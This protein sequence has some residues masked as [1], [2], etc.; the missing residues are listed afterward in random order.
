MLGGLSFGDISLADTPLAVLEDF[1]L[2]DIPGLDQA[3]IGEFAGWEELAISEVPGLDQVPFGNFPNPI[4]SILG[5]FGGTHDVTYGP[6]EH[7]VTPTK[8]A[9]TGSDQEGFSVQCAQDNGCAYLELEGPGAM[10]GAQWIAGG[11]GKGQQ[12]VEGGKGLLAM[13][14]GGKEPTGRVPF[15]DVFKI[16]LTGTDE[17]SGKGDFALYMR[18][19]QKAM[20]VDLGC[21]PY[22]IGPIPIWS[23]KEKGFVRSEERRVGKECRSRWSPYH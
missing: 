19:C 2:G 16:V 10:H 8:F 11:S 4:A 23:T 17:A 9:I 13:V 20:F 15:G 18:Y 5:G 21:T 6:K 1:S 3:A 14:N 7:T 22:F 12:M